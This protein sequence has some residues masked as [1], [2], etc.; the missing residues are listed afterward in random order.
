MS[1]YR[2]GADL[3]PRIQRLAVAALG[4]AAACLGACPSMAT[5]PDLPLLELVSQVGLPRFMGDW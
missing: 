5:T 4:A 3:N 2:A 1:T